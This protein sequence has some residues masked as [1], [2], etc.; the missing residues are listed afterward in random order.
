MLKVFSTHFDLMLLKFLPSDR[1]LMDRFLASQ[2]SRVVRS[3]SRPERFTVS[4]LSCHEHWYDFIINDPK[5]LTVVRNV[6][7]GDV[8]DL[9]DAALQDLGAS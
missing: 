2:T 3:M 4:N 9:S 6:Q 8:G 5:V 1:C 7:T